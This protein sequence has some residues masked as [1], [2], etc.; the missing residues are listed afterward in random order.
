[1]AA[2]LLFERRF[3]KQFPSVP[4]DYAP[5]STLAEVFVERTANGWNV[6]QGVGLVPLVVT[7]DT[8]PNF[9]LYN[10]KLSLDKNRVVKMTFSLANTADQIGVIAR[11][12]NSPCN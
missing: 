1:M 11:G 5:T 12:K 8:S 3:L 6:N 9:Y 2:L 10:P 7:D 4:S